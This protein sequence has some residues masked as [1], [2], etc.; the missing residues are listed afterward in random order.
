MVLEFYL[1]ASQLRMIGL[2]FV[3]TATNLRR[4]LCRHT[5]VFVKFDWLVRH[6]R[7]ALSRAAPSRF[8]DR[9]HRTA[10]KNNAS[11]PVQ[12]TPGSALT[13]SAAYA[14]PQK[15]KTFTHCMWYQRA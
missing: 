13:L 14:S 6:N 5:P 8:C 15:S 10:P 2:D 7:P 11:K 9:A 3:K 4:L 12:L 1:A